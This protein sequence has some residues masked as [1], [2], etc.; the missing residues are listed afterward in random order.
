M[1]IY[2]AFINFLEIHLETRIG[3]F[4]SG[5]ILGISPKGLQRGHFEAPRISLQSELQILVL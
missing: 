1:T 3:V 5:Q 2:L 4:A